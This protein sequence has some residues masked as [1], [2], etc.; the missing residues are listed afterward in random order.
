MAIEIAERWLCEGHRRASEELGARG[1]EGKRGGC[2]L[3]RGRGLLLERCNVG[4]GSVGKPDAA[5]W[6]MG[7][8]GRLGGRVAREGKGGHVGGVE[9]S[10]WTGTRGGVDGHWGV[11][12]VREK[13]QKKRD[14]RT[15]VVPIAGTAAR[16]H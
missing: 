2:R 13:E 5:F 8:R 11:A 12:L 3:A 4:E 10:R 16:A 6:W 1:E 9:R 15:I 14:R 7:E